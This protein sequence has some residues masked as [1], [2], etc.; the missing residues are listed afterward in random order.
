MRTKTFSIVLL[1]F[2]TSFLTQAQNPPLRIEHLSGDFYVY[3]TY[4]RYN[5]YQ[6]PANGMYLITS[7]G[8]VMFDTPWD[9]TQF[10]P[11]LDSI[12]FRHNKPVVMAMATHWCWCVV[13][14]EHRHRGEEFRKIV[15]QNVLGDRAELPKAAGIY[16]ARLPEKNWIF[17]VRGSNQKPW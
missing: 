12:R 16:V 9:T 4:N 8:V 15:Q 5:D 3:T 2:L 14:D 7:S 10:Q 17:E 1:F 11:L 6:V 13:W